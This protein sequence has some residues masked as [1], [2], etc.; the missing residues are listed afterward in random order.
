MVLVWPVIVAQGSR[1]S[2][3]CGAAWST[4]TRCC[5]LYLHW[6]ILEKIQGRP[7]RQPRPI[8]TVAQ[9]SAN[10]SNPCPCTGEAKCLSWARSVW[11]QVQPGR[12]GKAG[13]GRT[14]SGLTAPPGPGSLDQGDPSPTGLGPIRDLRSTCLPGEACAQSHQWFRPGWQAGYSCSHRLQKGEQQPSCLCCGFCCDAQGS[15]QVL[16]PTIFCPTWRA[17]SPSLICGRGEPEVV[18]LVQEVTGAGALGRT[19]QAQT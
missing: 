14:P 3:Q 18:W 5:F 11:G 1:L 19:V 9:P 7:L 17:P 8:V 13:V 15:S 6:L 16:G 4:P 12:E 10:L 2:H